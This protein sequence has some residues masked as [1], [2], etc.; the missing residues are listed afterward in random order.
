VGFFAKKAF[1]MALFLAG[2]AIVALFVSEYYGFASVDDEGLKQAADAATQAAQN[3]GSFL[4]DRLGHITGKGVSATVGF[5][6][7]LKM[8]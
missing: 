2:M 4:V 5:F 3:S 1:K 6:A 7:G 8:G